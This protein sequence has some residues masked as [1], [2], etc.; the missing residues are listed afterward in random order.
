MNNK[1]N[2]KDGYNEYKEQVFPMQKNKD[3]VNIGGQTRI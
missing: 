1:N 2:H 3:E